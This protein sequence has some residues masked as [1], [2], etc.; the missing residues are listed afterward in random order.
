M[1]PG[2]FSAECSEKV[3]P[4]L[5][6]ILILIVQNLLKLDKQAQLHCTVTSFL[7]LVQPVECLHVAL[8][9]LL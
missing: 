5:V 9:T 8:H 3:I 1:L 7:V 2:L 4:M 6:Y